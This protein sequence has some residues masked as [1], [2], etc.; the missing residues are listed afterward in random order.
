MLEMIHIPEFNDLMTKVFGK[1]II[2]GLAF[3]N[4]IGMIRQAG[5]TFANEINHFVEITKLFAVVFPEN[6]ERSL[7]KI[8]NTVLGKPLCK[9]EQSSNWEN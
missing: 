1:A 8:C 9:F 3:H 2:T 7:A 6:K 4:D 5:L